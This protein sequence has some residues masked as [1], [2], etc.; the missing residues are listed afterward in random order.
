MVCK[1]G[2]GGAS[3]INQRLY[4]TPPAQPAQEPWLDLTKR[5]RES[6]QKGHNDGVAHH[7]QS[8][9]AAL[10]QPEQEPLGGTREVFEKWAKSLPNYMD[11]TRFEAGYSDCNTDYAW[12][13]W[14]A[15]Q[16]VQE[17]VAW[18]YKGDAEF[19]GKEWRDN[20][21]VTTSKQVADWQGKDIQ[22]LYTTPHAA[23]R[24]W[25]EPT[26][27]EWWDWWRVSPAADETEAEINFADFL[28][29]A[30]AVMTK[31]KEHIK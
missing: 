18:L 31:L 21:R 14:Q 24:P 9:K 7:K 15:A 2:H 10:A 28:I 30:Q 22:P 13:G 6:Y 5:D 8:V 23:Q 25:V 19:D 29:I 20:I 17:P 1:N 4:T 11:I 26:V 27:G 16:P 12:A 3:G